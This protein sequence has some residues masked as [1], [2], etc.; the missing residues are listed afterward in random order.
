MGTV[1]EGTYGLCNLH[2][3]PGCLRLCLLS[4]KGQSKLIP[5]FFF[6]QSCERG[7]E[8]TACLLRSQHKALTP[9]CVTTAMPSPGYWLLKLFLNPRPLLKTSEQFYRLFCRYWQLPK[10]SEGSQAE[11]PGSSTFRWESGACPK[12]AVGA[13][14]M[15]G[16]VPV[17]I[18]ITAF[19]DRLFKVTPLCLLAQWVWPLSCDWLIQRK[20]E[21][22]GGIG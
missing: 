7:R 4:L 5:P 11:A 13:H 21:C 6:T 12:P 22:V 15:F 14:V 17:L 19:L 8:V 9:V 10:A 18:F 3:L 16:L 20:M 2:S 1:D